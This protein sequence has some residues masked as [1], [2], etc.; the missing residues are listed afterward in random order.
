MICMRKYP[1]FHIN[2][3]REQELLTL[4]DV[5]VFQHPLY[6]YSYPAILKEWQDLVLESGF[7]FGHMGTRLAGKL[8]LHAIQYRTA[9]EHLRDDAFPGWTGTPSHSALAPAWIYRGNRRLAD[10]RDCARLC[11]TRT[12]AQTAIGRGAR[13]RLDLLSLLDCDRIADPG[14]KGPAANPRRPNLLRRSPVSGSFGDSDPGHSP[15][16]ANNA[17]HSA[18]AGTNPIARA[19]LICTVVIGTVGGER[20]RYKR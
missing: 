15:A 20:N 3:A 1:D 2:V 18:R 13:N 5:I 6:W 4:H 11:R 8:L 12:A 10:D 19:L 9:L 7:A 17:P 14:G 16:V